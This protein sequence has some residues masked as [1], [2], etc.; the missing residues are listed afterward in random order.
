MTPCAI[1]VPTATPTMYPPTATPACAASVSDPR[2]SDRPNSTMSP[3][4]TLVK[5]LPSRVKVATSAAPDPKVSAI[6]IS[7][8]ICCAGLVFIAR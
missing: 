7:V 6:A 2:A 3:V 8:R 5:T 1:Q 4:I